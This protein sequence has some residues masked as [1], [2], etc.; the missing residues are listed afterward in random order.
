MHLAETSSVRKA[1][2]GIVTSVFHKEISE[3]MVAA[4]EKILLANGADVIEVVRV[5]GAYEFP[6]AVQR[7]LDDER[8]TLAVVLGYIEKGDTLHGEVMGHVVH[9]A[10]VELQ[11]SYRKPVG[12]GI[13]GPGATAEQAAARQVGYAEDAAKAALY[14]NALLS[15]KR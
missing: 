6:M 3:T 9:R 1:G 10:L 12:L 14:M 13:I 15:S 8:I 5:P 7:L 2:A 11:L 4:A